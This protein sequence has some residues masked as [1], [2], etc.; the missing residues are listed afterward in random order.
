[1]TWLYHTYL[2][3]VQLH[4]VNYIPQYFSAARIPSASYHNSNLILFFLEQQLLGHNLDHIHLQFHLHFLQFRYH[5][6]QFRLRQFHLR[7]HRL[8]SFLP[9]FH[10]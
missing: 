3:Q 6:H 5:R 1:M 2:L 8:P 10:Y 7:R 9:H 4:Q